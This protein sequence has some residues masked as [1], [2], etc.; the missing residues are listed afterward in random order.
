M[1]KSILED[2]G[3]LIK[4]KFDNLVSLDLRKQVPAWA[5]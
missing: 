1:K 3:N 2:P 4:K 5:E